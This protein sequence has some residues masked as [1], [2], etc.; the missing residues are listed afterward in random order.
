MKKFL[1]MMLSLVLLCG[2]ACPVFAASEAKTQEPVLNEKYCSIVYEQIASSAIKEYAEKNK[3]TIASGMYLYSF[4]ENPIAIFYNL[5]PKGYAIFDFTNGIVLE[6]STETNNPFFTDRDVR[7]YY[8]GVFG[9]YQRMSDGK[10]INLATKRVV[11]RDDCLINSAEDFYFVRE[12][13]KATKME[14]SEEPVTLNILRSYI[15]VM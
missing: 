4:D 14:I 9:Y 1:S 12:V 10:F 2:L 6:Y 13:P 3:P 5:A 15:I 11:T 7:Y 8:N